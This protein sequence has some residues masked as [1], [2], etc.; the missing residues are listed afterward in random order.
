MWPL[1][2][3][4]VSW[5]SRAGAMASTLKFLSFRHLTHKHCQVLQP[6]FAALMSS[7]VPSPHTKQGPPP[8]Q[9]S[10]QPLKATTTGQQTSSGG[11]GWDGQPKSAGGRTKIYILAAVVGISAGVANSYWKKYQEQ[12]QEK[13]VIRQ[14]TNEAESNVKPFL[15]PERPPFFP[16][17]RQVRGAKG[18]N[19]GLKLTL[20]QYATCPF[21][22]KARAFLDYMGLSYDIIEVNSV[23]RTQVKWS[24][25]KKVPILVAE[26]ANGEILQ[27]ND[28]TMIISSLYSYLIDPSK[29]LGEYAAMYPPI[30]FIDSDGKTEKTDMSNKYFI[31]F[32]ELDVQ[33]RKKE[34]SQERKWRQWV[35]NTYVHTLSPNVYRTPKESLAAF[36]WFNRVGDWEKHFSAWERFV[37][38]YVGAAVMWVIS[39]RLKKR[40]GL[41][42]D[43]RQSFY[44]ETNNWLKAVKQKGGKFL[45]GDKPNLADLAVF[46]ALSAVEGC[47]AF[48]DLQANTNIRPWFEAT[49]K[50]VE[51][52]AGA[53]QVN[54]E[55]Q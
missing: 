52:Q 21:C 8:A 55:N 22:C 34:V 17:A 50:A 25:Y 37:V 48:L 15:L 18:D 13:K 47:E 36:Q 54:V 53:I 44:D 35:D 49:K 2:D 10:Q 20:Y 3:S 16:P 5:S 38:I 42:E 6:Q 32:Q 4:L 12:N 31:M 14:L 24:K 43:V 30:K 7:Q 46:G 26:T 40:H 9:T 29:G 28:S 39:K 23:M 27:L 45:G 1:F 11:M 41:K 19:Q 51:E 33:K